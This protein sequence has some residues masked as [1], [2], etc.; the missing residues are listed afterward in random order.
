[1]WA[2]SLPDA[3][4]PFG[5]WT[6]LSALLHALD[7]LASLPRF[8][9]APKFEELHRQ[10]EELDSTRV[11]EH[12]HYIEDV[13]LVDLEE[14]RRQMPAPEESEAKIHSG[15]FGLIVAD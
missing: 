3:A 7:R 6:S 10:A 8:R 5:A 1:M 11:H 4:M 14:L 2:V 9:A 13:N 15:Q 12:S